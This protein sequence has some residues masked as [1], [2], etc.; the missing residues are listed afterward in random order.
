MMRPNNSST[1][2]G[3]GRLSAALACA[4][5]WVAAIGCGGGGGGF[6]SGGIGGSGLTSGPI[7]GFGSVIVEGIEFSTRS[8]TIMVNGEEATEGDLALGMYVTVVGTVEDD[9]ITGSAEEVDYDD[10]VSG[11]VTA[12]DRMARSVEVLGQIVILDDDTRLQGVTEARIDVGDYVQVSG[13]A[14]ADDNVRATRL[15]TRGAGRACRI[16]GRVANLA[17]D[18]SAFRIRMQDIDASAATVVGGDL[19]D[20]DTVAV[21]ADDCSATPALVADRIRKLSEPDSG[22]QRNLLGVLTTDFDGSHFSLQRFPGR[23]VLDVEVIGDTQFVGGDEGDLVRNAR[24]SIIG[25]LRGDGSLLAQ[26]IRIRAVPEVP[27][28]P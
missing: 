17:E 12:V 6:S 27:V 13:V 21:A 14:D 16:V 9:G 11:Q 5:L 26:R 25:R 2:R 28:E 20:G 10:A 3:S 1:H 23:E 7:E 4:A 8:A 18:G 24:I 15:A 19:A 22:R